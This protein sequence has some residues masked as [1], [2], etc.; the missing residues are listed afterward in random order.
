MELKQTETGIYYLHDYIPKRAFSYHSEEEIQISQ[1][2]WAYKNGDADAL[3]NGSF[4]E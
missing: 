4:E 3:C 1:K 2:I